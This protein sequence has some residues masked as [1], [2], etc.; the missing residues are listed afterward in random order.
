MARWGV[1]MLVL[2][3]GSFLLPYAGMQFRLLSLF[4]E[5]QQIAGGVLALVGLLLLVF[6]RG[7]SG[8]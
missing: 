1:W 6:G 2:G 7:E 3:L 8:E 4:G 5:Y